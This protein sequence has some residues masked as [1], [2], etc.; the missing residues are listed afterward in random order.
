MPRQQCFRRHDF[1]DFCQSTSAQSFGASSESAAL[2]VSE[3]EAFVAEMFAENPILF[4]QV[5]DGELLMLA[6]PAGKAGDHE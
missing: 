6:E 2:I 5:V 4:G 3:A 1:G